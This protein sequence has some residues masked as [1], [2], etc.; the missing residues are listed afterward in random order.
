[1]NSLNHVLLA[2][3]GTVGAQA[4]EQMAIRMCSSGAKLHHLIVVPS[5]WKGMT[6]DDWLN[7]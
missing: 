3:H 2:S 6:G 4:A 1:M 5:L 7:N